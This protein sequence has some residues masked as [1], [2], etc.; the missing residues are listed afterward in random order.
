MMAIRKSANTSYYWQYRFRIEFFFL[1]NS[2]IMRLN[3]INVTIQKKWL[4]LSKDLTTLSYEN[5]EKISIY[6]KKNTA[7][8]QKSNFV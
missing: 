5:A 4:Q 6:N 8:F 7:E 1:F 3:E 2:R